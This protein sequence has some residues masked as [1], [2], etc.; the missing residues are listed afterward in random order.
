MKISVD[1]K[2]LF[3]L[4]KVQM[5]IFGWEQNEDNVEADLKRRIHWVL[6]HKLDK[7]IEAMKAEWTQKLQANGVKMIPLDNEE[8]AKLVFIQPDYK[9]RKVRDLEAAK[10]GQLV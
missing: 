6:H 4:N 3:S 8:F 9:S 7:L 1:D 5:A 10:N 2:E